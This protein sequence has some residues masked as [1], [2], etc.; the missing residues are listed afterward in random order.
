MSSAL[1][2]THT[3]QPT[4]VIELEAERLVVKEYDSVQMHKPAADCRC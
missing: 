1:E 2:L 3:K 4:K